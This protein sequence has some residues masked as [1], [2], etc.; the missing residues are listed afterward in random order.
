MGS[1]KTGWQERNFRVL[2]SRWILR[3]AFAGK[4][5]VDMFA[6]ARRCCESACSSVLG[7][8]MVSSRV[9]SLV[10]WLRAFLCPSWS[11]RGGRWGRGRGS[12]LTSVRPRCV[13]NSERR[14]VS[15]STTTERSLV[16]SG[17]SLINPNPSSRSRR[18][19]WPS[20]SLYALTR[21]LLL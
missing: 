8:S 14:R 12:S 11:V 18:L 17:G 15:V 9:F 5:A 10:G 6:K 2:D 19:M 4:L 3:I 7:L 13:V 1:F 21:Q 16:V 20:I